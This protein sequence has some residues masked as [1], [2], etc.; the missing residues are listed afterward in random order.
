MIKLL[1]GLTRI[2][3]FLK[4]PLT[5]AA[6]LRFS[7]LRQWSRPR[8]V[9]CDALGFHGV[10]HSLKC[11]FYFLTELGWRCS[12]WQRTT[13]NDSLFDLGQC[14]HLQGGDVQLPDNFIRR[15]GRGNQAIP[16]RVVDRFEPELRISWNLGQ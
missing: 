5:L 4:S 16:N 7:K 3:V 10:F 6:P 15:L 9:K 8:R 11:S 12:G 14:Q 13:L 2:S 1:N